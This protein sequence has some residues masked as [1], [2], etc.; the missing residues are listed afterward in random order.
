MVGVAGQNHLRDGAGLALAAVYFEH[1]LVL[2]WVE[3]LT[4]CGL[5]AS[6]AVLRERVLQGSFAGGDPGEQ[7]PQRLVLIWQTGWH[8]L[9]CTRQIVRRLQYAMSS[10]AL[11]GNITSR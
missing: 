6:D 4:G 7:V 3:R 5:D 10:P 8:A 1:C 9:Q 11:I 2:I